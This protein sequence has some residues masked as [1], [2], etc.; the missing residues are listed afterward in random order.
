MSDS[1]P[2]KIEQAGEKSLRIVWHDSHESLYPV[3]YLRLRCRCARCVDE[4]TG[5]PLLK[6]DDVPEDVH[7]L[8]IAPVGRYAIALV[9]VSSTEE[10]HGFPPRRPGASRC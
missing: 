6:E 9:S 10:A 2:Q 5:R 1:T 8:R 4:M 7:P 3:R